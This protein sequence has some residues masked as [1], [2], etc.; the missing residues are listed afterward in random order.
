MSEIFKLCYLKNNEI[1]KIHVYSGGYHHT[2]IG[3][4]ESGM[5]PGIELG[6]EPGMEPVVSQSPSTESPKSIESSKSTE[7]SQSIKSQLGGVGGPPIF[8]ASEQENIRKNN[9]KVT[10]FDMEIYSDDTIETIK[11]KNYI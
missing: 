9:I 11:K 1:E 5:K 10:Y 8:N 7:L 4:T 6:P 3:E 2:P